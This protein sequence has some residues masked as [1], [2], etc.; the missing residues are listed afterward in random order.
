MWMSLIGLEDAAR[1]Q[2]DFMKRSIKRSRAASFFKLAADAEPVHQLRAFA[3]RSQA[4]CLMAS[5]KAPN[6][7]VTTNAS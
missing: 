7:W 3:T 6:A 5:L 4:A 2:P 1:L